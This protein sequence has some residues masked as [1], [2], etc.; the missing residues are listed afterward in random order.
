MTNTKLSK[1][2]NPIINLEERII[3][4]LKLLKNKATIDKSTY[5]NIRFKTRQ[6]KLVR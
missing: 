6:C 3:V 4:E 1:K 2:I 5:K